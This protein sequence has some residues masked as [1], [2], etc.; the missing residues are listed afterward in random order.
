MPACGQRRLSS[1]DAIGLTYGCG[2]QYRF[3][4]HLTET[5]REVFGVSGSDFSIGGVA[6][7]VG[8]Q[9]QA[10]KDQLG[11]MMANYDPDDPM[12]AFKMEMEVSKYKAEIS[13]MSALVKDLS[14]V[15]QQII[16]KV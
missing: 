6:N 10:E 13:L 7:T 4:N 14:E 16:Q 8:T 2:N 1:L 12:S 9:L 5:D 15:Q 11:D 3:I